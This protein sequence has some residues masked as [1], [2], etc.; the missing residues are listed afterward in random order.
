VPIILT[1]MGRGIT[2]Y[3]DSTMTVAMRN[4]N[5]YLDVVGTTAPHLRL[6]IDKLGA[7]RIMFGTDWSAT[8]RWLT[9]PGTLHQIRMKALDGASLTGAEHEQIHWKTAVGLFRLAPQLQQAGL[10]VGE[11]AE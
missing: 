10:A 4:A 5:I 6:A 3:F 2:T 11:A 8:W 1:K 9:V 7:D